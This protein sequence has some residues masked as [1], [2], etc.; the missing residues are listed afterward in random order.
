MARIARS[1]NRRVRIT[2]VRISDTLLYSES[3][4]VNRHLVGFKMHLLHEQIK[5]YVHGS[6][7]LKL[8]RKWDQKNTLM[9]GNGG[10]RDIN[11]ITGIGTYL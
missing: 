8:E 11:P 7:V 10:H 2:E 5:W 3:E 1:V 6:S 9:R 4:V